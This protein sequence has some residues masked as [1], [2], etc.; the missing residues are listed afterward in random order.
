MGDLYRS[1]AAK[2]KYCKETIPPPTI[3]EGEA[4][5]FKNHRVRSSACSFS[6]QYPLISLRSFSNCLCLLLYLFV[7]SIPPSV[8]LQ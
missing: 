3:F 5:E 8:F 4:F 6:F 2:S 7:T 1:D